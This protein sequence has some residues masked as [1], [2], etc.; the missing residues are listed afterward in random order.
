MMPFSP[1]SRTI[2]LSI[3]SNRFVKIDG[4]LT[5][6]QLLG[7]ECGAFPGIGFTKDVRYLFGSSALTKLKLSM[8]VR[9]RDIIEIT[10]LMNFNG[11]VHGAPEKDYQVICKE[12]RELRPRDTRPNHSKGEFGSHHKRINIHVL[13]KC[14]L[15]YLSFVLIRIIA[16]YQHV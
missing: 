2:L 11:V 13:T 12:A 5:G 1:K 4:I 10:C 6:L 15:E 9:G 3:L 16:N 8:R 14:S 7:S